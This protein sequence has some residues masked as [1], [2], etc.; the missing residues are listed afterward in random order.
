MTDR[1]LRI[2]YCLSL[3]GPLASNGKT[4]R[5]AHQIWKDDANRRGGLLGRSVEMV[6]IDDQSTP[7]LVP[8]I[9][10]RLLDDEKVDLVIGGYSDNSVAPAMPLIVER[11]KFFVALMSLAVNASYHYQNYFVMIPTGPHPTDALTEGFFDLAARQ[12]PKPKTM[13]I[14]AVDAPFLKGPVAGAKVHAEKHGFEIVAERKY[15]LATTEFIPLIQDLAKIDPDILFLSSYLND[16]VG[17]LKAISAVGLEPRIVGGSMIGPQNGSIKTELG[18][19]LNGIVNYE[20]WLPVPKMM[21]PGIAEVIS[22]YQSRSGDAGADPLGY[23]A[24]PQAYAQMQIVEQAVAGTGSL[25]DERL[26]QFTRDHTFQTILGDVKF[27]E[28]GGWSEARILQVQYQNIRGNNPSQFKG[29]GTQT[30][31]WPS[32]LASGTLIYPY[33][34]AKSRT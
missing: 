17:L 22:E 18:P 5:L 24:A 26:A 25:D 20:Y 11:G 33:A 28:G 16:T 30:V 23:Y 19:L 6:C 29:A 10:K 1:N 34:N 13:A 27:G 4:A 14:L 15:P 31:V 9:Y 32:S 2:G 7:A 8:E 21:F 12:S 3:S